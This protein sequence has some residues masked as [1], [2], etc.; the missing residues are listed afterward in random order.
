MGGARTAMYGFSAGK[1]RVPEWQEGQD[2]LMRQWDLVVASTTA[3]YPLQRPGQSDSL[4]LLE[5][6]LAK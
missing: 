6:P 1:E 5:P 4:G 3:S 2:S